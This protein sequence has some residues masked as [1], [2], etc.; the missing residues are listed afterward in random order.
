M[1]VRSVRIAAAAAV[2]LAAAAAAV[3][4]WSRTAAT[5]VSSNWSGYVATSA[6]SFTAVSARWVV[7]KAACTAGSSGSTATWVGLGGNDAAS[8]KLEQIGS[9]IACSAA[10]EASYSLWYELVPA[11]AVPIHL[12]VAPGDSVFA[13]VRVR[14]TKVTLTIRNLTRRTRFARTLTTASP[15]VSSAEWI[16]EAPSLCD[17]GG[18]C[19]TVSLARFGKVA[20]TAASAT[21]GGHTGTISDGA[22][23]ATAIALVSGSGQS[24]GPPGFGPGFDDTAQAAGAGALPGTLRANGTAFTVAWRRSVTVSGAV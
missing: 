11:A 2:A 16:V 10:G 22:W 15:D 21:A 8:N 19:R 24:Y 14:G 12:T 17:A 4:A 6:R 18:R 13:S 20:F 3:P 23:T 1:T 9:E 7:P 5:Q